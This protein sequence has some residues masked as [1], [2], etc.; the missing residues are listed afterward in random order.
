[1]LLLSVAVI[2]K[3]L[4]PYVADVPPLD[5]GMVLCAVFS[6]PVNDSLWRDEDDV[7]G[8]TRW[9]NALASTFRVWPHRIF[10]KRVGA[11]LPLFYRTGFLNRY[12]PCNQSMSGPIREAIDDPTRWVLQTVIL[13]S[14]GWRTGTDT[15]CPAATD[16]DACRGNG[17]LR[18]GCHVT[19]KP[20]AIAIIARFAGLPIDNVT[21]S[22]QDCVELPG[23]FDPHAE[24]TTFA[25][26][27]FAYWDGWLYENTAEEGVGQG[28]QLR[29]A[30]LLSTRDARSNFMVRRR[31]AGSSCCWRH[32][33]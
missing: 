13:N 20:A 28:Q 9:A 7:S 12:V 10:S 29:E 3:G 21:V 23:G 16:R 27:F 18:P 6:T 22:R 14:E 19:L 17:F 15:L 26:A 11:G 24:Q 33:S 31:A 25:Q 32:G 4:G 8:A 2:A 1:M 30:L 5:Y